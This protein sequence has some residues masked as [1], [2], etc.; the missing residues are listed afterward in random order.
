MNNRDPVSIRRATQGD[1]D[2]IRAVELAAF[3][4]LRDAG[5]VNGKP[6]ASSH[7]ALQG[8]LDHCLLYVAC[9]ADG[10][11]VG[12]CGAYVAEPWLHVG[13]IDVHPD[14][15]RRGVG[16][17]LMLAVLDEGR[18]RDLDGAT[19]TTDRFAAFNAP[20]YASLGFIHVSKHD[21]PPRLVAILDSETEMGMDPRRRAAMA[22]TFE[23]KRKHG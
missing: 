7:D 2:A 5:G 17:K 14:W 20:F 22:L 13:E 19:L 8:Y 15:Q 1:F 9:H 11:L 3:E 16:R 12:F 21:C 6:V 23:R 4:T 10:T 18:T